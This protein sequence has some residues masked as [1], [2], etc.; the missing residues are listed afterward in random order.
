ML[1]TPCLLALLAPLCAPIDADA[2][3]LARRRDRAAAAA[4]APIPGPVRSVRATSAP[5]GGAGPVAGRPDNRLAPSPML[6]TFQPGNYITVRSNGILG[7]GYA[8]IGYYGGNN[9][10]DVYGPLSALR[11][12]SAPVNTV[13]RGYNGGPVAVEGTTTST[14]FL[15]EASAVRYPTRTNNYS[16][17]RDPGQVPRSGSGINWVDQD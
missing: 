2:G 5:A 16:A 10:M 13:V 11:A 3:W 1:R 17:V 12:T 8:P 6:G 4:A 7:G 15:P 9:S 14:P